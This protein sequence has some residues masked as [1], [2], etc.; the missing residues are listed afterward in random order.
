MSEIMDLVVIEKN[1]AMAVF[2]NN[3]QLDPLI[4]AIEKE[5][6]SLVPDV[7]TKK[8]RDA[9]ASMAHKVARSK[10]YID[11]AGKDL[12]AELKALPK[13]IDESRRVVRERLDALKDEVRR[14]L[15][16]WEAEQERIKAEEAMNA[17]HAEALEMNIKFDQELA[18]K[19][20]ADHEMALLMNDALDREQAEK[21]AEAERQR[22]AREEEIKRLAEEKAKREAAEQAQRE[23]DAAAAREREAILAKERAEREQREAAERAE[24]EKQAAVEAERRKAQEEA[25]RIRRE[26]EKREQARLAEEKRK[27]DEQARREAD[28]KHRKAVGAEVVKALMANTS[29]TR[30]QAIEV[31][32]A[33]KDGRIPHAGISY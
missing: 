15:T 8:G 31:L 13:Q 14:P 28:V 3:D 4:E 7:T 24:R 21:K 26:A 2:T 6:R 16:E 27:A 19:F 30:D 22:I 1:N 11:N 32:T 29:L 20:E 10:T 18:A 5:A 23:I 33:V 9:I 25:D 12:V 17:L